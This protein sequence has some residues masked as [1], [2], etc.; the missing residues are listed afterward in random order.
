M[1]QRRTAG[2]YE[3]VE[4]LPPGAVVSNL[5]NPSAAARE[6]DR[7]LRTRGAE[8]GLRLADIRR[9][10]ISWRGKLAPDFFHPNDAGYA[11]MADVLEPAVREALAD[12]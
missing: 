8:R 7:M 12:R 10:P 4:E 6:V 2:S 9:H 3:L 5:P 11:A 1:V